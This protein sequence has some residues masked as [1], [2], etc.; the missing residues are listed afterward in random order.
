MIDS[1][2][3]LFLS[4]LRG[5]RLFLHAQ[6]GIRLLR[7]IWDKRIVEHCDWRNEATKL[8]SL[9]PPGPVS[10]SL[11][12]DGVTIHVLRGR[13]H[14]AVFLFAVCCVSSFG[15][16]Q[17]TATVSGDRADEVLVVYNDNSPISRAIADDYA[18]KRNVTNVIA[19]RCVDSAVNRKNET[20]PLAVYR[21]CVLRP[22][23][24]YLANHREIN[25][26]VLTKGIPIRIDGGRTGSRDLNNRRG[27]LQPSVDSYLAALDYSRIPNANKISITGSGATGYAWLNRYWAAKVPFSH[28]AFGG[29]LVT[30][31]D[32]YTERDAMSLVAR[33]LE[34]ER[35]HVCCGQVL[36][37]VQPQFGIDKITD[38]PARIASKI[39][40][41]SAWGSWN[42]DLVHA[43][44][45]LKASSIPVELNVT[46]AFVGN[47][48]NLLGYFSWGSNDPNYTNQSYESLSFVPGSIGDTAVSTSARTF[49]PT[50][51]GQSLIADLI[52]HGITGVK[53]YTNEPLLQAVSSPSIVL[54]RYF[55]GFTLA[56]SFYAASRFVGWE[57]VVV[58]DPLCSSSSSAARSNSKGALIGAKRA[59]R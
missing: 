18:K 10:R 37:D 2:Y 39:N 25:F 11:V 7:A 58:G 46:K 4:L 53:G 1:P 57:D 30:R 59:S 3:E 34:A 26:I 38:Q 17:T 40:E 49:L 54:D 5:S 32:G 45:L 48:A 33:A 47:Q 15:L 44:D 41:E 13:I 22:I 23:K 19:I 35:H 56:E 43:A 8:N 12:K 36:L 29:Y 42:A 24:T 9:L 31:L 27:H 21:K 50:S 20:I 28:A 51:G 52:A 55:S 16:S 14:C 6:F